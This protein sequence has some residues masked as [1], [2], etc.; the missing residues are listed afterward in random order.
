MTAG[1]IPDPESTYGYTLRQVEQIVGAERMPAFREHML[2]RAHVLGGPDG[3]VFSPFD[4]L[5]FVERTSPREM[6]LPDPACALGYTETQLREILGDDVE[7]YRAWAFG[8]TQGVCV[9]NLN[10]DVAHGVIHYE[11][12]VRRYWREA[13]GT[14]RLEPRNPS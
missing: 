4:V 12:D 5:Q 1:Q 13:V 2:M 7:A 11:D 10:C 14:R 6:V 9:G 8:K 3:E